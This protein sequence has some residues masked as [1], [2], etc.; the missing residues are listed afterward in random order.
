MIHA[1]LSGDASPITPGFA[2]APV[3]VGRCGGALN[4][5][6][7]IHYA[8]APLGNLY[9]SLLRALA[10]LHLSLEVGQPLD[11]R[12][13]AAPVVPVVRSINLRDTCK[14]Q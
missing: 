12:Q 7:A 11:W 8:G 9:V 6:Q 4:A 5:N 1:V 10:R 14:N 3:L 2:I 13:I